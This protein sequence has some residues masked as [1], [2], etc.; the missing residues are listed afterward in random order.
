VAIFF[1]RTRIVDGSGRLVEELLIPVE[2]DDDIEGPPQQICDRWHSRV[3]AVCLEEVAGR[4]A[5]LAQE[6][7]HGLE[8]A[9]IRESQLADIARA[10]RDALVQPGLFDRR[11]LDDRMD[12]PDHERRESLTTASTLLLAQ[13]SETVL[14]IVVH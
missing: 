5:N 4:I 12:D 3:R 8:R 11:L 1:T 14:L 6:Y 10:H 7:R 2:V 13:Q 9:R